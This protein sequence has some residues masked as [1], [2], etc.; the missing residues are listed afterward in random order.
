[1][2]NALILYANIQVNK[3]Y[4]KMLFPEPFRVPML[5]HFIILKEVLNLIKQG[6][7]IDPTLPDFCDSNRFSIEVLGLD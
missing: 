7:F 3:I 2:L 4:V 6:S 1:M 5:H